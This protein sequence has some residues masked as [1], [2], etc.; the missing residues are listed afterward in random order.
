[1]PVTLNPTLHQQQAQRLVSSTG[2]PSFRSMVESPFGSLGGDNTG[3]RSLAGMQQPP[4]TA[5]TSSPIP[6]PS[7]AVVPLL[8]PPR[9]QQ[10]VAVA[11]TASPL[12]AP[13]SGSPARQHQGPPPHAGGYHPSTPQQYKQR[14]PAKSNMTPQ[15][16]HNPHNGALVPR[17]M[18]GAAPSP[19]REASPSHGLG[20]DPTMD[21]SDLLGPLMDAG[22]IATQSPIAKPQPLDQLRSAEA[23]YDH[24]TRVKKQTEK[25]KHEQQAIRQAREMEF[26][27]QHKELEAT[28]MQQAVELAKLESKLRETQQGIDRMRSA[29]QQSNYALQRL[30]EE[31]AECRAR[32]D[33]TSREL[34]EQLAYVEQQRE[35]AR[36]RELEEVR[37]RMRDQTYRQNMLSQEKMQVYSGRK[38]HNLLRRE[39]EVQLKSR[40]NELSLKEKQLN[41]EWEEI[42]RRRQALEALSGQSPHD[43]IV[44]V[45]PDMPPG[46]A[47]MPDKAS[48]YRYTPPPAAAERVP[49]GSPQITHEINTVTLAYHS[50][51]S[52]E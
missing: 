31:R 30:Q 21:P 24:Y 44:R 6:G 45:M 19:Q 41:K 22:L 10:Q 26:L 37:R 35:M 17:R 2:S 7:G 47:S 4:H 38:E 46:A 8:V 12:K 43:P 25:L 9:H 51:A 13:H 34:N 1:M 5:G 50:D 52:A 16:H 48:T 20:L 33:Q 49:R 28:K 39:H 42:E 14:P 3:F 15:H 32:E 29:Q 11:T 36:Q 27:R 23:S 18:S 40:E